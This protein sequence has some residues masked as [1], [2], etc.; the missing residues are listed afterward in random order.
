VSPVVWRNVPLGSGGGGEP[1]GAIRGESV[2]EI[3]AQS[4]ADGQRCILNVGT[5]PD[6]HEEHLS[7]LAANGGHLIGEQQRVIL[8][9]DSWAM[10]LGNRSRALMT[11]FTRFRQGI[12][13]GKAYTTVRTAFN[14]GDASFGNGT[15]V[16]PVLET[17]TANGTTI[18]GKSLGFP[19]SGSLLLY[20]ANIAYTGKTDT[21]F[22]GC[23]LI[24]G[25]VI[26][27]PVGA[28]V[29][30]GST[31]GYGVDS[32]PVI[33]AGELYAAGLH[34][35]EQFIAMIN[36]EPGEAH[37]L[38]VAPYWHEWN[39][40]DGDTISDQAAG[41]IALSSQLRLPTPDDGGNPVSERSFH[42]ID[43]NGWVDLNLGGAVPAKRFLAPVLMGKMDAGAFASGECLDA[44]LLVR[45]VS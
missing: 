8:Q 29:T 10:D 6:L 36:D 35:Q 21:T 16:V 41:G 3:L 2:A 4:P 1:V 45:W 42:W 11:E 18:P 28:D 7:Y 25:D 20:N 17:R 37:Q 13:Y 32:I 34:L 31:G 5:W 38:T 22:T 27:V 44:N 24:A 19:T 14:L 40:G 9:L 23:T 26:T 39:S 12:P 43:T 15:G 33:R 30:V